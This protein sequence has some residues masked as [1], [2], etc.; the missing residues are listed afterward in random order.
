MKVLRTGFT[1]QFKGTVGGTE[2]KR[3]GDPV[4]ELE[5]DKEDKEQREAVM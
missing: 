5:E 2:H 1:L 4:P 3:T